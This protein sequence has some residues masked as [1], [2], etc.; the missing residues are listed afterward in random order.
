M[1]QKQLAGEKAADYIE[2][3]MTV[4]LGTGSTVFYTIQK[5]GE[6]VKNGLR[7]KGVSTSASTTKL[8]QSLGIP[9]ISIDDVDKID[10]TI[11]GADE[12]D[13]KLNGIKG[14]G[15][16]LLFEKVVAN[17]SAKVIWVVDPAKKVQTL[18]KF[19]LPVEVIP[20]GAQRLFRY[21]EKQGL[22]PV[23]RDK[24]NA[25]YVTDSGHYIIDLHLEEIREPE[26]LAT[27]LDS[28]TGVVEHGLFLN[29]AD[30]IV[31]GEAEGP[32]IIEKN[33]N[34]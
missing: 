26:Q 1:N 7:I 20:F 19:P 18:G 2:D 9:L 24:E 34:S 3:G 23:I 27:W 28:L 6:A 11:D 16:A 29:G 12:V 17:A 15:G 10:L 5:V 25:P 31:V 30:L 22:S 33:R 13:P 14:G 4:G 32:E 8:A 21:F